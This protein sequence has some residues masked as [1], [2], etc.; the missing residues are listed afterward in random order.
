MNVYR[1]NYKYKYFFFWILG[2]I[3]I[4]F[5][6]LYIVSYIFNFILVVLMYYNVEIIIYM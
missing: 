6:I 1:D 3:E 2:D 4:E 5:K